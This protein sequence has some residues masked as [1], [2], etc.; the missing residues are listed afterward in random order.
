MIVGF[1]IIRL[2]LLKR[3][4]SCSVKIIERSLQNNR[5]C[6]LE[7]AR[8]VFYSIWINLPYCKLLMTMR[9]SISYRN[10]GIQCCGSGS[11]TGAFLTQTHIFESLMKNF[12]VKNTIILS[13]LAKKMSLSVQK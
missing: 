5:F 1:G 13:V 6:F 7:N 12:W 10:S 11:G 3:P 9:K 8:W 2:E 4:T